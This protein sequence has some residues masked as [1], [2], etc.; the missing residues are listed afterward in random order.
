MVGS[1]L[2]LFAAMIAL[3]FVLNIYETVCET[4]TCNLF[5]SC[6]ATVIDCWYNT[7]CKHNPQ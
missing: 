4:L 3:S 7:L 1:A 5:M 2:V 6:M